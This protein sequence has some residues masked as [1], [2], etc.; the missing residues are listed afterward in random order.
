M[1]IKFN[2]DDT[3]YPGSAE[4]FQS[5]RGNRGIRLIGNMPE[6]LEGFM[7]FNDDD[8][9]IS[10]CSDYNYLYNT[11]EY[12]SVEEIPIES[13]S[14]CTDLG[15]SEY[16]KLNKKINMVNSKVNAITPYTAT[17]KA[18]AEDTKVV[19]TVYAQGKI[20][21][22]VVDSLGNNLP[23]TVT[24]DNENVTVSFEPLEN[25]ATVTI[26]IV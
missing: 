18:Y 22:F 14:T 3:H 1:Y 6:S 7:I 5:Q 21:A 2:N 25:V 4:V 8:S 10:D 13:F 20:T 15:V 9:L 23:C 19:F 12:L 16:A 26:N 11:N 24:R 17:K